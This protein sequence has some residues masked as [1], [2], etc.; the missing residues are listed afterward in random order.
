MDD[1]AAVLAAAATID[2]TALLRRGGNPSYPH[3]APERGEWPDEAPER[4]Y[5]R[6][7]VD[8]ETE[9]PH[10]KVILALVPADA[11]WQA[12]AYLPQLTLG[13]EATPSLAQATGVCRRWEERLGARL[14]AVGSATLEWIVS[15]PPSTR[16]EA[17]A[18]A[19]EHFAFSPQGGS[20]ALEERAAEL[21]GRLWY[22]WWD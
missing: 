8:E 20:E 10:E 6:G 22:A 9:E 15:R 1:P 18:L 13:G 21:M 12:L 2:P 5:L 14:T 19:E 4:R 16:A 3:A 11:A 7:V 17:L